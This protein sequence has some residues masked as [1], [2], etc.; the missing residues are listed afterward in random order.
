LL[1]IL[2]QLNWL[3]ILVLILILRILYVSAKSGFPAEFF[4]FIGTL[5]AIYLPLHYY[6]IFSASLRQRFFGTKPGPEFLNFAVFLA[7]AIAGW[8]GF[9][10]LR[11]I[12]CRLIKIEA[13][14][15]L[16]RWG[17]FILGAVRA[18]LLCG[19]IVFTL[20]VSGNAYLK[21]SAKVSYCGKRLSGV[22]VSA[23]S[24]LWNSIMTKFCAGEKFN[25]DVVTMREEFLK[26]ETKRTL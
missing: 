22:P 23:Y 24:W 2:K 7:L 4:K 18:V 13:V 6:L 16:N 19:L 3:D 25:K 8:L 1:N 11:N 15:S 9:A 14:S 17:G 5:T 12:F 26:D 20:V 10:L 21:N